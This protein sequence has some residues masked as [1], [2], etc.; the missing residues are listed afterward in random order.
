MASEQPTPISRHEA[1]RPLSREHHFGLQL[2]WKIRRGF[3][4]DV[5]AERIK[6]YCDW[7]YQRYLVPHFEIEEKYLF[8]IMGEGNDLVDRAISDHRQ[9]EGFIREPTN[10]EE[11]LRSLEV[12]LNNHIRFEER[13][14]FNEIQRVATDEQL[15]LMRKVHTH[16]LKEEKYDDEFWG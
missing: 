3:Q 8:P 6:A 5:S 7:F 11:V 1:L 14:L 10:L 2:C 9:I 12:V 4:K 16:E 15:D 13:V